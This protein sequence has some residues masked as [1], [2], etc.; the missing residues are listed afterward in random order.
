MDAQQSIEAD[1]YGTKRPSFVASSALTFAT[2][3]AVGVL[4]LLNVVIV[5]RALGPTGRGDV[6]FLTTIA[7]LTSQLSLMGFDQ[8]VSNFAARTPRLTPALATDAVMLAAAFGATAAGVVG[9]LVAIV[10]GV[11][12]DADRALLWAVLAALPVLILSS[13]LQNLVRAHYRFKINNAAY[14]M[15]P[16]VNAS[17]NAILAVTGVLTVTAAVTIWMAG[18]FLQTTVLAVYVIRKLH[19]FGRPDFGLARRGIVFGIKAHAGRVM[20]FGNYQLDGWILGGVS[21]SREL[22]YYS[23]AVSWSESLFFLPQALVLVQRP[24]LVRADREGAREAAT[25]VFRAAVLGTAV[26][27]A[28]MFALAPFLCVTLFGSAFEESVDDLRILVFGAFGIAALK[29]LGNALTAQGRPLRE[30]AAVGVAFVLILI[31]DAILIPLYGGEGAAIASAVAYSA[32][33]VAVVLIFARTLGAR[34][35]DL[36]PRP[37]DVPW[38]IRRVL[39]R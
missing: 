38:L 13:Y 5:A 31:L 26:G 2:Y 27:A 34:A 35:R 8:A 3:V 15:P 16:V 12:G 30:T 22:G 37:G 39:R 21:G 28:A 24:D 36:I 1:P 25:I 17:V 11:A 6:A 14:L 20:T 9:L 32:G 23:V 19:G 18:Q 29:L 7:N 33:G 10:P 4:S